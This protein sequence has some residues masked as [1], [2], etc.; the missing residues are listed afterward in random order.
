MLTWEALERVS[1]E[2]VQA[3]RA[4]NQT[5]REYASFLST[6]T[7]V[8]RE[9]LLTLSSSFEAAKYGKDEP[10]IDI[11]DDAIKALEITVLTI[12]ESGVRVQL[13]EDDEEFD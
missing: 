4:Y 8:D 5:A 2:I 3:P 10:S 11:W 12:I 7:I 13:D 1:R 9:T 6:V